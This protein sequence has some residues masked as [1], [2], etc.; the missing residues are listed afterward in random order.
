LEYISLWQAIEGAHGSPIAALLRKHTLMCARNP[1]PGS[2]FDKRTRLARRLPDSLYFYWL[3]KKLYGGFFAVEIE[4]VRPRL[5]G[6]IFYQRH[7]SDIHVF[8]VFTIESRR[9]EGIATNALLNFLT[10]V[11]EKTEFRS[12]RLGEDND[13]KMIK[14]RKHLAK[15]AYLREL[16]FRLRAY[17]DGWVSLV[18]REQPIEQ[19]R[20]FSSPAA[21]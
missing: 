16:P 14:L 4:T 2:V 8:S 7:A 6:H 15:A 19:I 3:R 9:G 5:I 18:P 17:E 12:V 13:E 11:W 20:C 1:N 10:Q 21:A